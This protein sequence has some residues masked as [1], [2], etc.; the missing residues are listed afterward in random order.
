MKVSKYVFML[1]LFALTFSCG[2]SMSKQSADKEGF[3]A[4]EKEL[5]AKFGNNAHYTDLNISYDKSV[6]NMIGLTV[7]DAPETL[8]MGSYVFSEH[9]SWKQNS[10]VTIEIPKGTKAKDYMFQLD[11]KINLTKLGELVEKS[12]EQLTTDKDL[13]N[14]SFKMGFIKYPKNGDI[15]KAE[16]IIKLEPQNGGTSFSFY[17]KLNGDL[18]KMDY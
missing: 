9:T 12:K 14:P 2:K 10:E 18:I 7:T 5:K 13:K 8:K 1:M 4:I 17:Y 3:T 6:G 16:Y 11:D 15:S